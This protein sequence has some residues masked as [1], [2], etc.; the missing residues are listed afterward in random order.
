MPILIAFGG[1]SDM[2]DLICSSIIAGET[3]NIC[4]TFLVFCAVIAVIA[5]HPYTPRAENVFR[6]ACMPA[7][8]PESLPA[9]DSA[10]FNANL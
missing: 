2:T 7:P 5:V 8:A 1:M 3:S 4:A 9:I 10:T 6:S